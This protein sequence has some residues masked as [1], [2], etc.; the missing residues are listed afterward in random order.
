MPKQAA[1][2]FPQ[3]RAPAV[4]GIAGNRGGCLLEHHRDIPILRLRIVFSPEEKFLSKASLQFLVF[5]R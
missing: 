2:S 5:S 1:P 4:P 3:R